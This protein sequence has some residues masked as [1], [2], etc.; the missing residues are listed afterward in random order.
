[1]KGRSLIDSG[2][3]HR[4]QRRDRPSSGPSPASDLGPSEDNH[5]SL[6]RGGVVCTC[7][8]SWSMGVAQ[9]DF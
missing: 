6:R 1:M 3:R 4:A 9:V 8:V 5:S 2:D 7:L